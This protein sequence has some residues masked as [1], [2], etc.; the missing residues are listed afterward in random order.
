MVSEFSYAL[1]PTT[2]TVVLQ[3]YADPGRLTKLQ[4]ESIA[5]RIGIH[6]DALALDAPVL[7]AVRLQMHQSLL[8]AL[9]QNGLIGGFVALQLQVAGCA[10]AHES[11]L[12]LQHKNWSV[13]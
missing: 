5:G 8:G 11:L 10:I 1:I 6:R 3:P 7:A 12:A 13:H 9:H 4:E 2:S